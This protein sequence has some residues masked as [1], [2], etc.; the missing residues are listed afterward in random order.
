ML[1]GDTFELLKQSTGVC[2]IGDMFLSMPISIFACVTSY[3]VSDI[4]IL[5]NFEVDGSIYCEFM[6]LLLIIFITLQQGFST[7]LPMDPIA[8]LFSGP[9]HS[10]FTKAK[11]I[12]LFT[13]KKKL[14]YYINNHWS[15]I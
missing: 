15:S 1:V 7:F 11:I 12:L 10:Y 5:L 6:I 9:L 4:F 2:S 14:R 8:L 3:E 13:N